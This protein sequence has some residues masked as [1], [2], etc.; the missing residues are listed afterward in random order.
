M[1]AGAGD[2]I[3]VVGMACRVPGAATPGALWRNVC[4]GVTGLRRFPQSPDLVPVFGH[5]DGLELF[6]ASFFGIDDGTARLMDP[7]QRMF[8][9]VCWHALEDAGIDPGRGGWQIGVFGGGAPPRYQPE[10]S[11][12]SLDHL[13][14]RV[15]Y[16]LG[17]S[18]PAVAVQ[19]AC[20]SSLVAVCLAAQSL[21]DFRCDVALAGG[22]AVV[23]TVEGGYTH[24]EGLTSPDGTFLPLDDR[25]TGSVFGNGCGVV[26]LKR[27]A[28]ALADKDFVHGVLRGL[29]VG[30]DG[31]ARAGYTAPGLEGQAATMLEALRAGEV[32][33]ASIGLAELH[34]AGTRLGDAVELA[35]LARAFKVD[36]GQRG[37][38]AAGATKATTG[39]LDAAAGVV[40]LIK[41]TIAVREGVLPGLAGYGVA[42]AEV[43]W[44]ENPCYVPKSTEV[45]VAPVRRALVNS[46]GLGGT[47]ASV[48]V[49]QAPYRA[50]SE[51][52]PATVTLSARSHSALWAMRER[53]REH[54]LAHPTLAL[55]DVAFTLRVGRRAMPHKW[56]ATCTDL[57]HAAAALESPESLAGEELSLDAQRV[58][59][60]GYPF[61]RSRYWVEEP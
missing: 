44:P 40:G 6:D 46:F 55:T 36:T 54:L 15:A 21:N 23:S 29:A 18:G 48:V 30:N 8:L 59:L 50:V 9:E 4:E 14:M 41:A 20:S 37:Y 38:C 13:P 10:L 51:T 12:N 31:S 58:P 22:A 25:T 16:H 42:N 39:N 33:A 56:S 27:L 57:E 34:A 2:E 60:P 28:D 3:A 45:W 35:A 61:E 5:L 17:L 26:V 11:L 32:E 43:D 52:A 49:E 7:Q 24:R 53:L 19:S 47:N 1:N